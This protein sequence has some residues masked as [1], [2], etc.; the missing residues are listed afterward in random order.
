MNKDVIFQEKQN[1]MF[2]FKDILIFQNKRMQKAVVEEDT[3]EDV[4]GLY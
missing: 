4:W 1:Q 3:E 2:C